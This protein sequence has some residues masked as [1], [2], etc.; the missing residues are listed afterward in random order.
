MLVFFFLCDMKRIFSA[1]WNKIRSLT[2]IFYLIRI[3]GEFSMCM[4]EHFRFIVPRIWSEFFVRSE[5]NRLSETNFR[6]IWSE[7][8]GDMKQIF[9]W[10]MKR[11]F[12]A[13][14]SENL[15]LHLK[16]FFLVICKISNWSDFFVRYE[17]SISFDLKRYPQSV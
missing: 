6:A 17:D 7:F 12:R 15:I 5:N 2:R 3:W 14:W 8:A 16:R 1:I 4:K 13:I 9:G 10:N 11:F